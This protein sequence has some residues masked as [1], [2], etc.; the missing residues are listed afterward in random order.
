MVEQKEEAKST[1]PVP[2]A[3]STPAAAKVEVKTDAQRIAELEAQLKTKDEAHKKSTDALVDK[4]LSRVGISMDDLKEQE[5]IEREGKDIIA[6]NIG[7]A[8]V[9]INGIRYTGA[10]KAPRTIAEVVISAAANYRNQVLKEKIGNKY[11]VRQLETGGISAR[12]VGPVEEQ[13]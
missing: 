1:N 5:R 8:V 9:S 2:S 12:L 6:V 11:Q 10:F 4:L 13:F 3:K 7:R